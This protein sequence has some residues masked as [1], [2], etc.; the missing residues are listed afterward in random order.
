MESVNKFQSI[1]GGNRNTTWTDWICTN[2]FR[3]YDN[4]IFNGDVIFS[5]STNSTKGYTK[6]I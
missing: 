4:A 5:I 1:N 3:I 6:I 2:L